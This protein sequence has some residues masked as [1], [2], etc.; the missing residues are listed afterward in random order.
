[1]LKHEDAIHGVRVCEPMDVPEDTKVGPRGGMRIPTRV[2]WR[3]QGSGLFRLVRKMP[4]GDSC[5]VLFPYVEYT[6]GVKEQRRFEPVSVWLNGER[7]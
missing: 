5:P 2:I 6:N 1:M 4:D 7:K 3:P